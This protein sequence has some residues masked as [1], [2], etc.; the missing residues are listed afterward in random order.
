MHACLR[1][2]LVKK[3][4][5]EEKKKEKKERSIIYSACKAKFPIGDFVDGKNIFVL[6]ADYF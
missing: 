5:V 1:V 2:E 6:F 3:P 4:S